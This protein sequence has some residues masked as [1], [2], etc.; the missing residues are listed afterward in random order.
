MKINEIILEGSSAGHRPDPKKL[1][2]DH[3]AAI[4]G[5]KSVP[6]LSMNKSDGS[7]YMQYRH[8]LALACAGAGD[9]P[10]QDM[11]PDGAFSGDPLFAS[12]ADIEE[13]MIDN[14]AKLVGAS[15][16]TRLSSNKSQEKEDV[17]KH[18][19]VPHNSGAKRNKPKN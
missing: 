18:S 17:H 7:S 1:P 4:K 6:A 9:T 13:E 5:A 3:V 16:V 8:G 11:D 14:A 2:H 12:Y 19:A 15:P 10:S